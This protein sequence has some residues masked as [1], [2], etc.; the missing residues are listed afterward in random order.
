MLQEGR[1]YIFPRL[2]T[3]GALHNAQEKTLWP[4]DTD[5]TTVKHNDMVLQQNKIVPQFR[6]PIRHKCFG[7]K[8]PPPT[9]SPVFIGA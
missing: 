5:N 6:K 4:R 9:V 2:L 3:C 1:T 7:Q 8:A